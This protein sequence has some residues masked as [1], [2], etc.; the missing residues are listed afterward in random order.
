V[1]NYDRAGELDG[2]ILRRDRLPRWGGVMSR[3]LTRRRRL[4]YATLVTLAL[5]AV[6][7]VVGRVVLPDPRLRPGL[8][9]GSSTPQLDPTAPLFAEQSP[10]WWSFAHAATGRQTGLYHPQTWAN[11]RAEGGYRIVAVGDSTVHGP[12][13]DALAAGLVVP[14]RTVE[15]L[16]F[17]SNG[18]ASARSVIAGRASLT[19]DPDLVVFYASHNEVM[20]SRLEPRALEPMWVRALRSH[21]VHSGLGRLAGPLARRLADRLRRPPP[22]P[23]DPN[24]WAAADCKPLGDAEWARVAHRYRANLTWLATAARDAGVPLALVEPTSSLLSDDDIE[25]AAAVVDGELATIADGL[26]ACR[27]GEGEEALRRGDELAARFPDLGEPQLLR[28]CALLALGRRDEAVPALLD[29]RHREYHSTRADERHAAVLR[30]VARETGA[31]FVPVEAHFLADPRYL[32]LDDPLFMDEVH[33]SAA[34]NVAL[35]AA[36]AAG[37]AE[38]LPSGSRYETARVDLRQIKP[39]EPMGWRPTRDSPESQ[40]PD[41]APVDWPRRGDHPTPQENTGNEAN[42]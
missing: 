12:F 28:G 11:P 23:P 25:P 16:N 21:G 33:P 24:G 32:A 22:L 3:R 2:S 26:A 1:I 34:G 42:Q 18:F 38:V 9:G 4:L 10:G 20:Q 14:G 8:G 29:A 13:P 41:D 7:E 35:A 30:E 27:S 37:L 15:M 36:V 17:G 39:A 19:Q 31:V 40:N 5:L 6:L